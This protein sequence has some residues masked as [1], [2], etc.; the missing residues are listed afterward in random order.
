M[1][2]IAKRQ[3]IDASQSQ[4]DVSVGFGLEGDLYALTVDITAR[5]PG[6]DAET[7]QRPVEAAQEI[8]PCSRATRGNVSVTISGLVA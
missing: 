4:V 3:G 1:G 6:V 8:C 5:I 7:A 2:L